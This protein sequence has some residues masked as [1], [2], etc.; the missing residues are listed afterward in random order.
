MI[1]KFKRDLSKFKKSKDPLIFQFNFPEG[2]V[3]YIIK[4]YEKTG[5][6]PFISIPLFP[7]GQLKLSNI[8][9]IGHEG[10]VQYINS[11]RWVYEDP[12]VIRQ[13]TAQDPHYKY[14]GYIGAFGTSKRP[15]TSMTHLRPQQKEIPKKVLSSSF[16]KDKSGAPQIILDEKSRNKVKIIPVSRYA[17]DQL[18]GAYYEEEEEEEE[19]ETKKEKEKYCGT[20]YFWEPDSNVYLELGAT[21]YAN[22]KYEALVKLDPKNPLIFD[23]TRIY[24]DQFKELNLFRNDSPYSSMENLED[25]TDHTVSSLIGDFLYLFEGVE[26]YYKRHF[27]MTDLYYEI[28]KNPGD[29]IYIGWAFDAF[30]D[31]LDQ[32]LCKVAK[33]KGVDTIILSKMPASKRINTEI[34]D[35]RSREVSLNSLVWQIS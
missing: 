2:M 32:E 6:N 4:E 1:L 10:Q 29:G 5:I 30:E 33:S 21:F 35:T 3:N 11:I 34:L 13:K 14:A 12:I 19:G 18:K 8:H 22:N 16:V 26:K 24:F 7:D 31:F 28:P 9:G 17:V 23:A 20:F 15:Y 25:E 27:T